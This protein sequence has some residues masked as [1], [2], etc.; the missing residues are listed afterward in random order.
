MHHDAEDLRARI[1]DINKVERYAER[2][3]DQTQEALEK[4]ANRMGAEWKFVRADLVATADK[5]NF[6]RSERRFAT[7]ALDLHRRLCQVEERQPADC[8]RS[9]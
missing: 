3:A 1:S 7:A 4:T 8:T 6:E 9:T 2:V 5:L